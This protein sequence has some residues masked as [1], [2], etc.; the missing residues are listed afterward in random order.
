MHKSIVK[1]IQKI[2]SQTYQPRWRV[3]VKDTDGLYRGECGQGLNEVQFGEWVKRQDKDTQVV[4]VEICEDFAPEGEN[5]TFK[6][7]NR[8][9]MNTEDMLREYDLFKEQQEQAEFSRISIDEYSKE[10]KNTILEA[11]RVIRRNHPIVR[12]EGMH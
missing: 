3:V 2:E 10:E 11:H 6:V 9:G 12:V 7:E 5:V 1:R 8:A 4:I